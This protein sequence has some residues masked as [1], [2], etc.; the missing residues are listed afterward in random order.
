MTY[1]ELREQIAK[2]LFYHTPMEHDWE[3]RKE[4]VKDTYLKEA[5]EILNLIRESGWTIIPKSNSDTENDATSD[6]R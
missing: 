3:S 5:D 6:T 1:Q 2:L 4:W